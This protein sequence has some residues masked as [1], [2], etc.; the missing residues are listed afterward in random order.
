MKKEVSSGAILYTKENGQRYYVLIMEANG[1]YGLPK[2]HKRYNET[3]VE[4]ALREIK[5]ETGIVAS[6]NE[7]Y[8]RAIQYKMPNGNSKEVTYYLAKYENQELKP[9]DSNILG[10]KKY[11]LE[12][13]ISLI[14]FKQIK[15]IL[16][17]MDFIL[18]T[19]GE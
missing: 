1:S 5:E 13:A 9:E 19:L 8:K 10:A 12:T 17:E 18:D 2:G 16:L 14:K 7:K 6:I 4:C 3:L 15:D 11:D